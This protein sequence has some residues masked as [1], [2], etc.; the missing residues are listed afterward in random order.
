RDD[1]ADRRCG[2]P[3]TVT[4]RRIAVADRIV[5]AE[6]AGPRLIRRSDIAGEFRRLN[7]AGCGGRLVGRRPA[8]AHPA[9]A[10]CRPH[11]SPAPISPEVSKL[12]ETKT[13]PRN[14][15][16]N[17]RHKGIDNRDI[18]FYSLLQAAHSAR[19]A[20]LGSADPAPV[21]SPVTTDSDCSARP[22]RPPPRRH[23]QAPRP[24][25]G[26]VPCRAPAEGSGEHGPIGGSAARFPSV[27]T[28]AESTT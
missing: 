27:H 11:G 3:V 19:G 9:L 4:G 21:L 25:H 18:L 20:G 14:L 28:R 24:K 5:D 23:Q 17:C 2:P 26:T 22:H 6:A 1:P 10:V 7:A 15:P 13:G 12:P 16:R 8:G